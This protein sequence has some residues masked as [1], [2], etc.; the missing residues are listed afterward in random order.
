MYK[1]VLFVGFIRELIVQITIEARRKGRENGVGRRIAVAARCNGVE[2]KLRESSVETTDG[3]ILTAQK[4]FL[5]PLRQRA[6]A[7]G[8]SAN[9]RACCRK[10][11]RFRGFS[12]NLS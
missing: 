11:F 2:I 5:E 4:L 7:N 3:L 8:P 6:F 9:T 1:Q 12:G 10:A